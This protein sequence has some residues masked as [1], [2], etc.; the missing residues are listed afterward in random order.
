MEQLPTVGDLVMF[1]EECRP[2]YDQ[3]KGVYLVAHNDGV[4]VRLN[5]VCVFGVEGL[6]SRENF[7]IVSKSEVPKET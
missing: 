1:K 3:R 2:F 6:F 7:D 5:G 4:Y